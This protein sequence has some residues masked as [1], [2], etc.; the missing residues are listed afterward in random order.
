[1]I[2]TPSMKRLKNPKVI[3]AAAVLVLVASACATAEVSGGGSAVSAISNRGK[4]SIAIETKALCLKG[5]ERECADLPYNGESIFSRGA[6]QLVKGEFKDSGRSAAWPSGVSIR[7]EGRFGTYPKD[8]AQNIAADVDCPEAGLTCWF[9]YVGY[10]S[11]DERHYPNAT[12]TN[13]FDNSLFGTSGGVVVDAQLLDL[14][15]RSFGGV[16]SAPLLS[17]TLSESREALRGDREHSDRRNAASGIALIA[18]IDSNNN[19]RIDSSDRDSRE[20]RESRPSAPS[21]EFMLASLCGPYSSIPGLFKVSGITTETDVYSY[22]SCA[23]EAGIW[24]NNDAYW[25]SRCIAPLSGGNLK[26]KMLPTTTTST[27]TTTTL[28]PN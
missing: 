27:T 6:Y 1:M 16:S 21:D 9:A 28:P 13:C 26:I 24:S 17:E 22:A 11:T 20:G 23:E 19:G 18:I 15:N 14:V 4:I 8:L 25:L 12:S 3:A 2:G 7:F 5:T 10:Q